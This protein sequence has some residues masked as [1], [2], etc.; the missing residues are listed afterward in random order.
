MKPVSLA[1]PVVFWATAAV[2]LAGCGS[3]R[4]AQRTALDCPA[5][6][7]TLKRAS[8]S[9]D[10]RACSYADA[11]GDE[12]SLRLIPVDGTPAATLAPIERELQALTV[13]AGPASPAAARK[14]D[15]E[16]GAKDEDRAD[17]TLPGVRIQAAGENANIQVGTLHVDATDNGAVFREARNTRLRGEQLSMQRR[18]YRASYIVARNDLSG[19]L[20]SV[21]YEAGG[22]RTGPLTVA[23]LKMKSQDQVIHRDVRRLVRLNGGI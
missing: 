23:V 14:D 11:D 5:T 18:G 17:I 6:Q 8:V 2:V 22:P 1:L 13:P 15:D 12:V 20:T 10:G 3:N 19:G 7:G 9:P 21:G 4:A 16:D